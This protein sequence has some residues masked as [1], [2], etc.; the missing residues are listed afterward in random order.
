MPGICGLMS[1]RLL[2]LVQ[3]IYGQVKAQLQGGVENKNAASVRMQHK[4]KMSGEI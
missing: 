3:V 1:I 2:S 4:G